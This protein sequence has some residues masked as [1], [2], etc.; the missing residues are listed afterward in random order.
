MEPQEPKHPKV[1]LH[2][3]EHDLQTLR[4]EPENRE[5]FQ[6]LYLSCFSWVRKHRES[7]SAEDIEDIVNQALIETL[8]MLWSPEHSAE[9]VAGALQKALNR[10]RA[11]SRRDVKRYQAYGM[12]EDYKQA[13]ASFKEKDFSGTAEEQED[14]MLAVVKTL[15]GFLQLALENLNPRDY[16]LLYW[17][18]RFD[19]VGFKPPVV[20]LPDLLRKTRNVAMHRARKRFMAEL[21]SLLEAARQALDEDRLLIDDAL[22]LMRTGLIGEVLVVYKERLMR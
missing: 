7:L 8:D 3:D 13:F 5:V 20:P 2:V 16:V 6:A 1:T 21:E 10:V 11:R 19:Q 4:R 18:Y 22:K 12:F 14:H 17:A 15:K 9:E